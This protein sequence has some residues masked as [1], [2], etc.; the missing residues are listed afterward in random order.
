[1]PGD[2]K[3]IKARFKG[4]KLSI[5][6]NML[7]NLISYA[8]YLKQ[9]R[10]ESSH[11]GSEI[12]PHVSVGSRTNPKLSAVPGPLPGAESVLSCLQ[13]IRL[14][15]FGGGILGFCGQ[16]GPNPGFG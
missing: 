1:M 5:I 4:L 14:Y 12:L 10:L 15:F 6:Y 8:D 2:I 11:R 16:G 3:F 13:T 7:F 9:N